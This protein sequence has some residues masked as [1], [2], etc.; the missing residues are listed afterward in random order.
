[1]G[2]TRKQIKDGL[3]QVPIDRILSVSGQLTPKQKRF[4][5]EVAAGNSKAGAYRTAYSSKA[6]PKTAGDAGY[7]LSTDSRIA[8]EIE[9]YR[10][11]NEAAKHRTA[12][13]LRDLVIQSLVQ[14]VIDPDAKHSAKIS[15]A[16]VL[17]T[18]TEVAA[19]TERKETRVI[20]SSA[21]ARDQIMQQLRDMMKAGA[22]DAIEI[23][24]AELLQELTPTL[25]ESAPDDPTGDPMPLSERQESQD[26]SHTIPL[27][28]S[29]EID[30]TPIKN[31]DSYNAR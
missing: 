2:L 15:A 8:A 9:A 28:G 23:D 1:M 12:G 7:R 13:Q 24:A 4:A 26:G 10:L 27:K 22:S 18:V 29:P 6:K 19:F 17:G 20:T 25:V 5:A 11:A 30:H 3:Q 16:R 14:V 21:N 31:N